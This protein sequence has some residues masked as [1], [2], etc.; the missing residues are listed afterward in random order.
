MPTNERAPIRDLLSLSEA[1]ALLPSHPSPST[2]WR[3]HTI[4]ADVGAGQRVHLRAVRFG[5]RLFV[6]R[7]DLLAF[8]EQSA[9][10]QS[11]GARC[12]S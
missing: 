5:K 9:L 3:W 1:A 11:E 7:A 10:R 4:G 2:L 6:R 8:G 12:A